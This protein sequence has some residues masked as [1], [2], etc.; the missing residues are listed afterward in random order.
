MIVLP[1]ALEDIIM[2]FRYAK[3]HKIKAL[4]STYHQSPA[5]STLEYVQAHDALFLMFPLLKALD[6]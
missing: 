2:K 5:Y 6:E 3:S 4:P 1:P